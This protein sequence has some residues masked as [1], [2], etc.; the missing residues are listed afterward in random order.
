VKRLIV[1]A[2]DFGAAEAV[3]VAVAQGHERGILTSASLMVAAPACA[4]AVARAKQLPKLRVGLHLVLVEGAPMLPASALPDLVRDGLFR[5]DMARMGADIFFRPRVRK[6]LAA[7][8]EAQFEAFQRTGLVL[9]HVNTH[10]H[11]H[12]HPT[13]AGLMLRI[14]RRYGMA[15]S[16]APIEPRAI[17]AAVEPSAALPASYLTEPWARIVRARY[18]GAGV[19]VADQVFGL[20]WSGAMTQDRVAGIV[21]N[22]PEGLSELYLHP[23]TAGGFEGAADGYAYAGELAALLAP[24]TRAAIAERGARLG[25]FSDLI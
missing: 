23:A 14:G 17:L 3:N 9:D 24:D 16:R 19:A 22:L 10:K 21:R 7:E 20:A 12:L 8:I 6:Q 1:T 25:G 2:D 15:A 18:R 4:D 11:Y 5:T 13:I